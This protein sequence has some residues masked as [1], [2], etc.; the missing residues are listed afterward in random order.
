MGERESSFEEHYPQ[1]SV[2]HEDKVVCIFGDGVPKEE[3]DKYK[4]KGYMIA[5]F[6]R[7]EKPLKDIWREIILPRV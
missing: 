6:V 3:I 4:E 7:G 2:L 1:H 5:Y